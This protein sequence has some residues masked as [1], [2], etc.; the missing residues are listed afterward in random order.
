M[1]NEEFVPGE[2]ANNMAEIV[3]NLIVKAG[4]MLPDDTSISGF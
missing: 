2:Y 4:K 1:T 3:E